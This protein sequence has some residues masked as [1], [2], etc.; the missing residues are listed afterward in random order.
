MVHNRTLLEVRIIFAKFKDIF[1]RYTL[2]AFNAKD[3]QQTE[4]PTAETVNQALKKKRNPLEW[5]FEA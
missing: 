5:G 2:I 4:V 3:E 1:C